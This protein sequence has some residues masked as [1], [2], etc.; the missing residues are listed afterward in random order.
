MSTWLVVVGAAAV[1]YLL[2]SSV[3]VLGGGRRFPAALEAR[4]RFVGPAV[5]AAIVAGALFTT[6]GHLST[7]APGDLLAVAVGG[8]AARRLANPGLALAVGLP[9]AWLAGAWG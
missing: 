6:D 7:V 2:R 4:M 5:M 1:T 8:A 3:L 9:V